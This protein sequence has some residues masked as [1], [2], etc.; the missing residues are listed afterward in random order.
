MLFP[1][2]ALY[3]GTLALI[4]IVL[5]Q[6]VGRVRLSTNVSINDGGDARLAAAMRRQANFVENVPLALILLML[7]EANGLAAIWLHLLGSVLVVSRLV[8]PFGI[9]P[10]VMRRPAR[11]LGALGTLVVIVASA[12]VAL[13]QGM[14]SLS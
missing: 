10:E 6:G 5:Q 14:L 11:F 1:I 9:H 4:A 3:A 2:S 7:L 12:A 8:H 13:S